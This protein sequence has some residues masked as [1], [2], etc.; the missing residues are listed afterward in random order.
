MNRNLFLL[1]ILLITACTANQENDQVPITEYTVENSSLIISTETHDEIA[2]PANIRS[3][4]EGFLLYDYG[5]Q[6]VFHFDEY[7][8]KTIEFGSEGDG[9]GEFRYVAELWS[10]NDLYV[11]YDRNGSKHIHYRNDGSFLNELSLDSETFTTTMH[12]HSLHQIYVPTNGK[13]GSLIRFIDT[14]RNDS[15]QFG[16][17][18]G[19]AGETIDLDRARQ[20]INSGQV[21]SFMQNQIL[22]S[23]NERG[24][25]SFQQTTNLLQHYNHS[26]D[27]EWE[28]DIN[29][30]ASKGIFEQFVERNKMMAERGRGN[31]IMLQFANHLE[32]TDPGVAVL[33]NTVEDTPLTVAW[34]PNDGSQISV[35]Q[36]PSFDDTKP[37]LFTIN[38]DE[39]TIFFA[40]RFSGEV[41]KADWPI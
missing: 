10:F 27:L 17:A 40:S 38:Q 33:L 37:T 3:T 28:V 24:V 18:V 1:S 31:I 14:E 2:Q 19:E 13:D 6:K 8:N 4:R 7:G 20:N 35:I 12:A 30:P 21:P 5:A 22:L 16:Q 32:A 9:P 11:L 41:F 36:F 34:I 15:Q 39:N 26:G 25:F 23:G 29:T